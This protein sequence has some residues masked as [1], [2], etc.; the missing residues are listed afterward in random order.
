MSRSICITGA[1]GSGKTTIA[2]ALA[3]KLD[4]QHLSSGDL[5]RR[6]ASISSAFREALDR[7]DMAPQHMM[8]QMLLERLKDG[9]MVMDGYPRYVKQLEDAASAR[10][11]FVMLYL[12]P[13]QSLERIKR[14][15]RDDYNPARE[16]HRLEVWGRQ[17]YQLALRIMDE[18]GLNICGNWAMQ[19]ILQK[20]ETHWIQ[21]GYGAAAAN[22][23]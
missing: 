20:I 12:P 7:G 6:Y 3:A 23:G 8:D 5:A 10:P 11:L 18:G 4:L 19:I 15:M 9:G 21:G 16:R 13:D 22:M 1:P 14:R 2:K 17:H